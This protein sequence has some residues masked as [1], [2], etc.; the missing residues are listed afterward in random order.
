MIIDLE[1]KVKV[2][3]KETGLHIVSVIDCKNKTVFTEDELL[4]NWNDII[5]VHEVEDE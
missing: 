4:Y 5:F 3:N 1:Q 2:Y